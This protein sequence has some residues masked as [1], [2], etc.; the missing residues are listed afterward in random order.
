MN[1]LDRITVNTNPAH[2]R[3][4]IRGMRI[5]VIDI[6]DLLASR[7]DRQEMLQDYPYLENEDI[8]AA[9]AYAALQPDHPVLQVA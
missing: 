2:G 6:I 4:C 7:I 1:H 5:R 8:T 3:L 9:L